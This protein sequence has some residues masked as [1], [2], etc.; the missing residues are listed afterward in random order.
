MGDAKINAADFRRPDYEIAP[1]FIDRWSPRSFVRKEVPDDDLYGVF[2]AARW[3][4]SASNHQPWS[5]IVARTQEDRERFHSFI[6][7]GNLVWCKEA[8]VLA[9]VI[10][11]TV[12]ERGPNA[13]HA[14]DA[15]TAWGYLALEATRRGLMAHAMGGFE[16]DKARAVLNVPEDYALHAVVAIGYQGEQDALPENLRE[17]EQPNG[18]RPLRESLFEGGFGKPAIE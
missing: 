12:S 17:R 3:A 9:V 16:R 5:F 14:F 8:P 7:P 6:L 11:R 2:E 1:L 4:P 15:G 18:R 10:S 13:F